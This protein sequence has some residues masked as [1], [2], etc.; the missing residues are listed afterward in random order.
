M[1]GAIERGHAILMDDYYRGRGRS[2]GSPGVP[3]ERR[4][5]LNYI[6]LE[7]ED[8]E[9]GAAGDRRIAAAAQAGHAIAS[10]VVAT[11]TE[12]GPEVYH[13]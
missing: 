4:D 10:Q 9:S 12:I 13:G 1:S 8:D 5:R 6:P 7:F 2:V 11:P 3:N